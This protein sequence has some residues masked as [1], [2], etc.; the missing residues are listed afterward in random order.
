[1]WWR[2]G[3]AFWAGVL[4]TACATVPRGPS[5]MVLP[6]SGKSLEQ[7]RIDDTACREWAVQQVGPHDDSWM[8]QRRYDIAYQQCMYVRGNQIPGISRSSVAPTHVP[9][10]RVPAP[11]PEAGTPPPNAPPPPASGPTR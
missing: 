7:F 5:V 11:S 1:M 9:G 3:V 4:L 6:G 8:M 10:Q 2:S